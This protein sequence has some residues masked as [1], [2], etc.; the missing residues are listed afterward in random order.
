MD[1]PRSQHERRGH[2][3]LVIWGRH[4]AG[5][6]AV[7]YCKPPSPDEYDELPAGAHETRKYARS[8]TADPTD[9]PTQQMCEVLQ[10]E[11]GINRAIEEAADELY[12]SDNPD[13]R[14]TAAQ[15][16]R[17]VLLWHYRELMPLTEFP[18][19]ELDRL[20]VAL[21]HGRRGRTS[22]LR[23]LVRIV[24]EAIGRSDVGK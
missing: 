16:I 19:L 1:E 14:C 8:R 22:I 15:T 3:L 9:T 13:I 6:P 24:R 11:V 2:E 5:R 10:V 21:A 4:M 17:R 7:P 12:Q 20:C 23:R 18:C